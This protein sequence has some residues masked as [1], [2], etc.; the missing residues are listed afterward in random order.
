MTSSKLQQAFFKYS[1]D[2]TLDKTQFKC[3]FIFLT[4]CK[5]SKP[6]VQLAQSKMVGEFEMSFGLF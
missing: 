6:D 3:A 5:P 2:H 1:T 4:G